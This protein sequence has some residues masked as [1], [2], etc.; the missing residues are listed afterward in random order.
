MLRHFQL[1]DDA[2][3]KLIG[4]ALSALQK[5]LQIRVKLK[6]RFFVSARSTILR[7]SFSVSGSHFFK[8]ASVSSV[9]DFDCARYWQ[10]AR[11]PA[12]GAAIV[13]VHQALKVAVR[14]PQ[15]F[16]MFPGFRCGHR[17]RSFGHCPI[18]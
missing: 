16:K 7:Q 4:S 9:G 14:Q 15:A 1:S 18:P 17:R 2:G 12:T 5:L 8:F 3:P 13:D 10:S 11:Q 6:H